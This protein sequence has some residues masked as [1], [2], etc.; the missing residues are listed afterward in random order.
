MINALCDQTFSTYKKCCEFFVPLLCSSQVVLEKNCSRQQA[1]SKVADDAPSFLELKGHHSNIVQTESHRSVRTTTDQLIHLKYFLLVLIVQWIS[2]RVSKEL[3]S[4]VFIV[5]VL[6]LL[7]IFSLSLTI[8]VHRHPFPT[9]CT[10]LIFVIFIITDAELVSARFMTGFHT[11]LGNNGLL[12][13]AL[14]FSRDIA[15]V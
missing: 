13:C 2:R 12:V 8:F 11:Y 10:S 7:C 14:N 1:S 4:I 9:I 3:V 5:V 15:N 6:H